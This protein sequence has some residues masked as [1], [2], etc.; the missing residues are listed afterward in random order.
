MNKSLYG[1]FSLR[2]RK[3]TQFWANLKVFLLSS[4]KRRN[5]GASVFFRLS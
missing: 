1:C 4:G 2:S 5:F 3:V